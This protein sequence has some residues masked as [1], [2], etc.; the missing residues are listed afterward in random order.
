MLSLFDL[1]KRSNKNKILIFAGSQ[2][3]KIY[4]NKKLIINDIKFHSILKEIKKKGDLSV[5]VVDDPIGSP[6]RLKYFT[7]RINRF[8]K[9]PPLEA[10]IKISSFANAI[11]DKRKL[12]KEYKKVKDKIQYIYEGVDFKEFFKPKFDFFFNKYVYETILFFKGIENAIEKENPKIL[13][14]SAE[15]NPPQMIAIALGHQKNLKS[16][17]IQHGAVGYGSG[18]VNRKKDI[19]PTENSDAPYLPLP[20][21]QCVYGEFYKNF[22]LKHGGYDKG[23]LLV[24]GNPKYDNVI[25]TINLLNAKK[26]KKKFSLG[27]NKKTILFFSVPFNNQ[28]YRIKFLDDVYSALKDIKNIRMIVKI[29][30]NEFN[31]DLHK[32][33]ISKKS[34]KNAFIFEEGNVFEL[35]LCSDVIITGNS[36]TVMD[37]AAIK[38]PVIMF[39]P[40]KKDALCKEYA[41]IKAGV[42]AYNSKQLKENIENMLNKKD[43][44]MKIIKDQEKFV[45]EFMYCL[46]GNSS[47]RIV[48]FVTGLIK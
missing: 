36:T 47:K 35:G 28:G 43:F 18:I 38:K 7:K 4:E 3:E 31:R 39:D 29:H 12:K 48:N 32:K 23:Q 26:L 40:S 33:I 37:M 22:F 17:S 6:L 10:Y 42:L 5:T 41:K 2:W 30:P 45:D 16:I 9:N 19:S 14:I 21:Y 27:L 1:K 24:T 34:I 8:S 46:D 11:F 44:S 15:M 13:V 20:D 25:K